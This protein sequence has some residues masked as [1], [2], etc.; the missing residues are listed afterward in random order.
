MICVGALVNLRG[1][2]LKIWKRIGIQY[3]QIEVSEKYDA[4]NILSVRNL[5]MNEVHLIGYKRF[6]FAVE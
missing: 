6:D 2:L 4:L 5:Q 1:F 3:L